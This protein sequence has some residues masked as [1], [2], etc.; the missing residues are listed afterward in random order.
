[1]SY[2]WKY[3]EK[4]DSLYY[5]YV[6]FSCYYADEM[7]R[8]YA[9][10]GEHKEEIEARRQR[11]TTY[12]NFNTADW[13]G[14]LAFI[15]KTLARCVEVGEVL[16]SIEETKTLLVAWILLYGKNDITDQMLDTLSK[17]CTCAGYSKDEIDKIIN[18]ITEPAVKKDF[19]LGKAAV[20]SSEKDISL[21]EGIR[22]IAKAATA[23]MYE[24]V[25]YMASYYLEKNN[26]KACEWYEIFY[27]WL[28]RLGDEH[29]FTLSVQEALGNLYVLTYDYKAAVKTYQDNYEKRCRLFGAEA[30]ET[31]KI[32]DR[33]ETF[34]P[35]ADL[36]DKISSLAMRNNYDKEIIADA[37]K[38]ICDKADKEITDGI[39]KRVLE[40]RW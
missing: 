29:P 13:T 6:Y 35:L 36:T 40:L 34:N 15:S 38:P 14:W 1:M 39:V 26:Y 3:E 16:L 9:R 23:G 22:L 17:T 37:L 12:H 11:Y 24:A 27:S 5:S 4:T 33:L 7:I 18:E 8:L 31:I 25:S 21:E 32:K 28:K 10:W 30:P 20:E 19:E 2:K